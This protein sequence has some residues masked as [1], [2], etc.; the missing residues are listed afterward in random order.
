MG[1]EGKGGD[2]QHTDFDREFVPANPRQQLCSSAEPS[3]GHTLASGLCGGQTCPIHIP[4]PGVL[5]TLEPG[6]LMPRQG[7]ESGP[8]LLWEGLPMPSDKKGWPR[9]PEAVWPGSAQAR[10]QTGRADHKQQVELMTQSRA[11]SRHGGS[12]CCADAGDSFRA[13]AEGSS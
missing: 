3:W 13:K 11:S 6:L 4:K 9:L 1:E 5:L 10:R 7:A 12:P 2:N 8:H